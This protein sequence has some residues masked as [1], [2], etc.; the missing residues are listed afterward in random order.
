MFSAADIR[1]KLPVFG[2]WAATQPLIHVAGQ[3][4]I[5]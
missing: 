3:L 4:V 2:G 1:P 5:L